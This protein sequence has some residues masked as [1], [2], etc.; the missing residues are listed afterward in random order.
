MRDI[1]LTSAEKVVIMNMRGKASDLRIDS[2]DG[3]KAFAAVLRDLGA[4]IVIL[5]PLVPVLSTL[6]L[7][8]NS[9]SE[10]ALFFS[11]WA[12]TMMLAGVADDMI[13][14][15]TGHGGDRSRGASRLV[16][17]PDAI[18]TL[19]KDQ[20]SE[21][22]AKTDLG[23]VFHI[24]PSRFLQAMGRDV[25]L[26]PELLLYDPETRLLTLSGE[27]R[28]KAK[29]RVR[30]ES[31]MDQI[32]SIMSDGQARSKTAIADRVRGVAKDSRGDAVQMFIDT[33]HLYDSGNRYN[34]TFVLYLWTDN[35]RP[36]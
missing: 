23:D 20:A 22:E 1:P 8:E 36:I 14:H 18:W 12:E 26:A 10:V 21:E 30:Q 32:R 11:W 15:H 7:D 16:D 25:E 4:E 29:K 31:T 19:T 9:N 35:P 17:E 28:G 27:S 34:G 6:N 24:S 2:I 33:G 13:V 3:R 5:D